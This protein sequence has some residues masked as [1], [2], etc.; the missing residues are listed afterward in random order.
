MGE[1]E[2][3]KFIFKDFKKVIG[4]FSKLKGASDE[5][6][7]NLI[8]TIITC[9]SDIKLPELENMEAEKALD[10]FLEVMEG[11]KDFFEKF[12]KGIPEKIK[13]LFTFESPKETS[14]TPS[15]TE[16]THQVN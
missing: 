2:I 9:G 14:S 8:N 11:N 12:A 16:D 10:L 5:E 7:G 3:H 1:H 13:S 15:Q 4:S 6:M